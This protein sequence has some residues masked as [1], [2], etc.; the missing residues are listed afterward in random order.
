MTA[1]RIDLTASIASS[2]R[3]GTG[4][5][6]G[7]YTVIAGDVA[8]GDGNWIG[9]HVTIGT[10]AQFATQKFEL[11]GEVMAGIKIGNRCVIREY[12]TVHQPSEFAT[13]IEDDCYLMSYCHVSHDTRLCKAVCLA[14]NTQIGGFSEIQEGAVIGLSAVV[15]QYSTIGA[16]AMVGMASVVSKDVPPFCKVVGNPIRFEGINKV[17]LTRNNISVA[18]VA[19]LAQA[20]SKLKFPR[21]TSARVG[22]L[23]AAFTERSA[24]TGRRSLFSKN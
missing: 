6:I 1:N 23:I 2:V 22:A 16:F 21:R 9:P 4:N 15:H 10:P 20:Y 11:T 3:I 17:G 13:I 18:D 5:T 19:A 7:A 24:N 12:S 8:I 14:N